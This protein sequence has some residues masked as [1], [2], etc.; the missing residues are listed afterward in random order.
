MS[1]S[2][3]LREKELQR[4]T[5]VGEERMFSRYP[6]AFLGK[7][8]LLVEPL[9]LAAETKFS[10][11][12]VEDA[13]DGAKVCFVRGFGAN[14][15]GRKGVTLKLTLKPDVESPSGVLRV[16]AAEPIAEE[17]AVYS[18]GEKEKLLR[19]MKFYLGVPAYLEVQN[20]E[21]VEE[22]EEPNYAV[23]ARVIL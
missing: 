4:K 19:Y 6:R 23:T 22:G 14:S 20:V 11:T 9:E 1:F 15:S 8:R 17:G 12:S 13:P 16:D 10:C 21:D 5:A 3:K 7:T 18:E 2:E